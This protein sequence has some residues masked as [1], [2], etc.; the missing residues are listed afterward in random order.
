MHRVLAFAVAASALLAAR[1]AAAAPR[2]ID[3]AMTQPRLVFQGD[4][5]IGVGHLGRAGA[6]SWNGPG[7][8]L[9]GAIGVT[10]KVELG[11]RTGVRMSTEA[12]A[13]Q[14]DAYGRT[15]WTET[16]GTGGS[17][18]ANPEA[19]VRWSF[20]SGNVAEI[21]LDGRLYLPFETG[22]RIGGMI[23]VPFAIH[24]SDF[25][26]IDTGV[27]LPVAFT[28]DTFFAL[29]L[30]GYFWFQPNEKLFLGPMVS[31]RFVD[32]GPGSGDAGLLLGFGLGYQVASAVDL[33]TWVLFPDVTESGGIRRFGGGFGVAFRIGE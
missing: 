29:S 14:A 21:G 4:A 30:P 8:N 15:L 12:R 16:W 26:R 11:L 32:P 6:P 2:W 33:K 27:Y 17:T 23:G 10:D 1:S 25:L 20:Y 13:I 9:E 24:A 31:V 19:R 22:T 28:Q 5:G 3:R 7:L 18:M